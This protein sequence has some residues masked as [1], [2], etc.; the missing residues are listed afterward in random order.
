MYQ[1]GSEGYNVDSDR[2]RGAYRLGGK[3]LGKRQSQCGVV[4]TGME[5]ADRLPITANN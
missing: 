3:I 2:P 5:W 4:R 1:I